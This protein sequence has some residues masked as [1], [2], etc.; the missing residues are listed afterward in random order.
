VAQPA[1]TFAR[2]CLGPAAILACLSFPAE[3]SAQ[4]GGAASGGAGGGAS[5]AGDR[6]FQAGKFDEAHAIDMTL[7]AEDPKNHAAILQL[8]RI[9]LLGNR[10][11][12]AETWLAQAIALAPNDADAKVMLAEAF[13]RRDDF[14][15]AVSTLKGVDTSSNRLVIEQYPT[16]DPAKLASFKGET[17]YAVEEPGLT[18]RVELLKTDPLPLV[19]I[20]ING[21]DEVVFF[22]DTGVSEVALDTDFA[23]ELHLPQFGTTQGTFSRGEHAEVGQSRIESLTIG[24][25]TVKNLP[26]VTLPLRQLSQGLGVKRIDGAIGTTLFYHFLTTLDLPHGELV[27]RPKSAAS[28][29]AF[30]AASPSATSV[31]IW[32]ASDHFMVGF[33]RVEELPSALLFVDSGLAGAGVKLAKTVIDAAGIKLE[34]DKAYEGAGAGGTLKI[35]P[36]RVG[37]LSFGDITE[38][39]VPGLYDGPFPWENSFGFFLAGMIGHD[40]LKAYAVTFDFDAMRIVLQ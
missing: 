9:A 4:S 36:Y 11:A 26:A 40:F 38:E 5:S 37:R 21:G 32:I 25:L 31:P 35:V 8:G 7:V 13:Y 15:H 24:G 3:V 1:M 10:L 12:E 34:E 28:A 19:S 17:P 33:G 22:I 6:L 16:L 30:A 23:K 29:A 2:I 20:R 27:L 18:A 14:D 39:N